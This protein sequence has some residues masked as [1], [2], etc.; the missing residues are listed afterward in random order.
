MVSGKCNLCSCVFVL[1]RSVSCVTTFPHLF[2]GLYFHF[3]LPAV[4]FLVL[5]FVPHTPLHRVINVFYP[6]VFIPVSPCLL[7]PVCLTCLLIPFTCHLAA[8]SSSPVDFVSSPASPVT[9]LSHFIS[10]TFVSLFFS[11]LLCS[12]CSVLQMFSSCSSPVLLFSCCLPP[13]LVFCHLFSFLVIY[14]CLSPV[15]LFTGSVLLFS[16]C[17]VLHLFCSVFQL[18]FCPV[19]FSTCSVILFSL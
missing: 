17:S 19:Q 3:V 18:F 12:S 9:F 8:A 4:V 5:P 10:V 16:I 2:H 14:L 7:S 11:W 13:V 6:L 1:C 15:L